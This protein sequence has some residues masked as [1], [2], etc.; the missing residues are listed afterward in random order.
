MG[1]LRRG[2]REGERGGRL[3]NP[4]W[5]L[6]TLT[7][8]SHAG[9]MTDVKDLRR[10]YAAGAL[11][12]ADLNPDPFRQFATWFAEA[13]ACGEIKEPN[14][15]TAATAGLDG[16]VTARTVLLKG[17]DPRGFVFYTNYA[18]TK[19][20]QLAE[21]PQM[22]LLFAWVPMERQ[23]SITGRVEKTSPEESQEYF[24]TRPVASQ[25]GAWASAQ[26]RAV[27]SREILERQFAEARQKFEGT[28]VPLPEFW[29]GYR[30]VPDT[31]EFWQGRRS[32]LHDR[33]LFTRGAKDTWS[34]ERL[35][36]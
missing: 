12:R 33:F 23:V 4:P 21:N 17:W 26:S 5:P 2:E 8:F 9:R 34:I 1:R 3:Q 32:R 22:A 19:A 30:V 31:M 13:A 15:M 16:R 36:P 35:S 11:R 29:G 6:P 25:I 27:P 24:S 7:A 18:S 10:D 14:A 28:Q 20:R